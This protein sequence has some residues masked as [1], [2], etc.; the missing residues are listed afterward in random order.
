MEK[1]ECNRADDINQ[2]KRVLY[3]NGKKGLVA[4]T[5]ELFEKVDNFQE[6]VSKSIDSIQADVKVLLRFQTQMEVKEKQEE[7]YEKKLGKLKDDSIK[8]KR[9]RIVFA[10]TTIIGMLSVIISLLAIL[11]SP[12]R[13]VAQQQTVKEEGVTEEEFRALYE[14]YKDELNLR[15]LTIGQDTIN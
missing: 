6:S 4:Y 14:K 9:W 11:Y 2:I 13:Q 15:G 5:S 8:T 10:S 3:G 7:A 12:P 1:H